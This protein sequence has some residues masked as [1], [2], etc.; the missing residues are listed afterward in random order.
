MWRVCEHMQLWRFEPCFKILEP[1]SDHVASTVLLDRK[2]TLCTHPHGRWGLGV[3]G[4]LQVAHTIKPSLIRLLCWVLR[5]FEHCVD[6]PAFSVLC[7]SE[8]CRINN[9]TLAKGVCAVRVRSPCT[10]V[11]M[12]LSIFPIRSLV[13]VSSLRC[14]YVGA[15]CTTFFTT[16]SN[17]LALVYCRPV[18]ITM[19]HECTRACT[20]IVVAWH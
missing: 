6:C 18:K 3:A 15:Q 9:L 2:P 16:Y 13:L 17:V 12:S 11:L 5:F 14:C 10:S 20:H 4:S 7:T 1:S 8:D 19:C